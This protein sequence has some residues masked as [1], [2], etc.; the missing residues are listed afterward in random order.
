MDWTTLLWL[1]FLAGIYAPVGSPCVIVLYPAY[2]SFLAGRG[3]DQRQPVSLFI[4]GLLI[5]AGVILSLLLGGI[6]FA[7]LLLLLGSAARAFITPAAFLLLL[8]FSILLVFD[9]DLSR[10]TGSF[11]FPRAETPRGSAFLLGLLLGVIILP[12]NSAAVMALLTLAVTTSGG[13]EAVGIFLAFGAGMVVPL[14]S[15]AGISRLRSRQ[16][17]AFLSRHRLLVRRTAGLAM[18]L[19]AAWYLFHLFL[20]GLVR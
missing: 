5:S 7:L 4:P 3:D 12:C 16:P 17:T 6:L 2:L 18:F 14:L 1:A 9:L 11:P 19:I 13:V 10:L 20:P 8:V 15:I